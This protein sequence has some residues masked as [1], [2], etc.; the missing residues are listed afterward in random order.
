M[1]KE[2]VLGLADE[3]QQ[4]V[5][6]HLDAAMRAV[7]EDDDPVVAVQFQPAGEGH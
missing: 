2:V 3:L 1:K 5:Q 4:L 7:V 6:R